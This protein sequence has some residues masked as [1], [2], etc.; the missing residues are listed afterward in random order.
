MRN[1]TLRKV[2]SFDIGLKEYILFFL[3][4]LAS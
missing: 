4:K 3:E 2:D 1:N